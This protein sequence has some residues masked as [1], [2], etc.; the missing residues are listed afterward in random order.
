MLCKKFTFIPQVGAYNPTP[1]SPF[2]K[3]NFVLDFSVYL[4]HF[5]I[6]KKKK[7]KKKKHIYSGLSPKTSLFYVDHFIGLSAP[8]SLLKRRQ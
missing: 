4:F 2:K 7:K 1:D 6:I 3:I 8:T 5:V